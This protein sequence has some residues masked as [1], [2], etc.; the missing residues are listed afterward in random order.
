PAL[1]SG[2]PG[3]SRSPGVADAAGVQRQERVLYSRLRR[4]HAGGEK[5]GLHSLFRAEPQALGET[6]SNDAL[7]KLRFGVSRFPRDPFVPQA[8][9]KRTATGNAAASLAALRSRR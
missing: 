3:E 7:E 5:V 2:L 4:Q 1:R 8:N 6:H 9:R